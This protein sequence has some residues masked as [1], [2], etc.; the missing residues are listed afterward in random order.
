MRNLGSSTGYQ[1]FK[2]S[3][4]RFYATKWVTN[5]QLI[6]LYATERESTLKIV[7]KKLNLLNILSCNLSS[8]SKYNKK[9]LE[10]EKEYIYSLY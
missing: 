5:K 1:W 7:P 2:I 4:F 9:L 8:L 6:E 3:L 10:A